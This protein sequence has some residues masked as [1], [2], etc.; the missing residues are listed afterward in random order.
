[1]VETCC[2]ILCGGGNTRW[3]SYLDTPR[4]HLIKI[5]G[6]ILLSRTLK[7]VA[8]RKPKKTIIVVNEQTRN[9][10]EPFVSKTCE[11]FTIENLEQTPTEAWKYLSSEP[12]WSQ[13]ERTINLLGDVWY[14]DD[15]IAT[16]FENPDQDWL[17]FGRSGPSIFT[18]C[19]YGEIYAHRFHNP[20]EHKDKLVVLDDLYRTGK[21]KRK[22]SGWA[23]YH[24]MHGLEPQVQKVGPRFV[25]INDFTEDFDFPHDYD[26][27]VAG[28]KLFE[29]EQTLDGNEAIKWLKITAQ[30]G[31]INMRQDAM[32]RLGAIYDQGRGVSAN[33]V[34][35]AKWF[36][37]AAEKG[38]VSA[39]LNLGIRYSNGFGVPENYPLSYMWFNIAAQAGHGLAF[40]KK[41]KLKQ[42]MTP[43]QIA[44]GH[45]LTSEWLKKHKQNP[46]PPAKP[47]FKYKTG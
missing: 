14:S 35:A 29:M 30:N 42:K 18:G 23:H 19:W 32:N 15:A 37:R 34:E 4:K 12:L 39:Q 38:S 8:L 24:L 47:Q 17:A 45:K 3:G 20:Q 31:D 1:M 33:N 36:H 27:W 46:R 9:F 10:Y 16:I 28:R 13:C 40:G 44:E 7:Q 21:C 26:R 41:E 5:E 11:L 43:Q 6:E 25:E 22:A 2:I